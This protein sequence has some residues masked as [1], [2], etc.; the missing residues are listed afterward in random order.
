MLDTEKVAVGHNFAKA[1]TGT[2]TSMEQFLRHE[3]CGTTV[4]YHI[5]YVTIISYGAVFMCVGVVCRIP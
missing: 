2:R 5:I 4:Y 3:V 1:A